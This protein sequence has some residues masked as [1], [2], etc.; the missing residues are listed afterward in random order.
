[1]NMKVL[2]YDKFSNFLY[3]IANI[4]GKIMGK[5]T[6]NNDIEFEK[7]IKILRELCV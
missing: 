2:I 1:M 5:T 7:L 6:I 3:L 4:S